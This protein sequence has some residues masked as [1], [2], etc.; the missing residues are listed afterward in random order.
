MPE[1]TTRNLQL[2]LILDMWLEIRRTNAK[3]TSCILWENSG[4]FITPK[5]LIRSFHIFCCVPKHEMNFCKDI[6]CVSDIA[7]N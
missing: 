1:H 7:G 6:F 5:V 2:S 4:S 3:Y